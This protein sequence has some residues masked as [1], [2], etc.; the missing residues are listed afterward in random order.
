MPIQ[1][2]QA[3]DYKAGMSVIADFSGLEKFLIG[4]EKSEKASARNRYLNFLR[5]RLKEGCCYFVKGVSVISTGEHSKGI[6]YFY[7]KDRHGEEFPLSSYWFRKSVTT[8]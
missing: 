3:R 7:V 4:V 6:V 2:N 5:K 8:S 1:F